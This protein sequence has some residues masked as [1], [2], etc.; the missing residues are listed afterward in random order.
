MLPLVELINTTM[1]SSD[2]T[3]SSFLD[4]LNASSHAYDFKIP[5]KGFKP[6]VIVDL[7]AATLIPLVLHCR[8]LDLVEAC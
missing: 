6:P 5:L 7:V 4:F 3:D 8:S 1:C 2:S